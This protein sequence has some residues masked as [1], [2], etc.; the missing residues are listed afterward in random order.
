MRRFSQIYKAAY[1]VLIAVLAVSTF[2]S[3]SI[4][5]SWWF[6]ALLAT[7]SAGLVLLMVETRMWRRPSMFLLHMSF[8]VIL[9]GGLVTWLTADEGSM[10]L[11]PGRVESVYYT[12][13]GEP[14][15]LGFS[16][17]LTDFEVLNYPGGEI[18]RDY[19]SRLVIDGEPMEL[20]VNKPL[21]VGGI[22][23]FQASFVGDD[24]SIVG[25]RA[26]SAGRAVS[27]AGYALFFVGGIIG[28]LR[29]PKF[30]AAVAALLLPASAIHAGEA[31]PVLNS[32]A[33][34]SLSRCQVIYQGRTVTVSTV[35]HDVMRK[36]YGQESYR[37]L[38]A[39]QAVLS[40]Q[41]FPREW[42]GQKVIGRDGGHV[43]LRDC[44]DS[45]GNY[46][47][48]A[49][50]VVDERAG[51]LIMLA[52]GQLFIMAEPELSR[53]QVEAEL[54]Y[55][56]LPL[57]L[58]VF[59]SLFVAAA[60]SFFVP[61]A[62]SVLACVALAVQVAAI[63]VECWLTG[64]GPFASMFDTLRLLAVVTVV[65]ALTVRGALSVGLLAAGSMAL[66]A[67][68]QNAN[69]MVTP[70]MPVLH[71]PWLSMHV[72]LVMT[73]YALLVVSSLMAVYGLLRPLAADDVRRRAMALL[74]PGV[75]LLGLGIF[76]GAVWADVAWGRYW[77]W[78]PKETWALITFMLYAVPLHSRRPAL[79]WIAAP[80][81]SVAMTYFG[82]NVLPSLHAYS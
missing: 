79:L 48:T 10:T 46:I 25:V 55:N 42:S 6:V 67:H 14:C 38:S 56:R 31:V 20:S 64:H 49:D 69:P 34:D 36:V 57:T 21:N 54:V 17:E 74:R 13:S 44:F 28:L 4:Y 9:G 41:A 59:V 43:S 53:A 7:V 2:L 75:F 60:L 1:F 68:L 45:D 37:G 66:V 62:A 50:P 30:A 24:T 8:L 76:S 12:R 18:A 27:F 39:E 29:R 77:G 33:V 80:V 71:S 3:R 82:V 72:T 58:I 19:V 61:G 15:P 65:L 32:Q 11:S 23:L 73:A 40:I 81:L 35:C 22:R 47:M 5:C 78:D 26:D 16:V 70:L 63:G 51:V 52:S